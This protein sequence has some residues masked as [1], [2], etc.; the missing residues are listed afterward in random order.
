METEKEFNDM[1]QGVLFLAYSE[2][3]T[4]ELLKRT[5]QKKGISSREWH[6]IDITIPCRNTKEYNN[7]INFLK[8]F[9]NPIAKRVMEAIPD[10]FMTNQIL[11]KIEKATDYKLIRE[12]QT[13]ETD[14]I[15]PLLLTCM[16]PIAVEY[17]KRY[18]DRLKDEEAKKNYDRLLKFESDNYK[19]KIL[20]Y[21]SDGKMTKD[22]TISFED[23]SNDIKNNY[24]ENKEENRL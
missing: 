23:L 14:N 20:R 19:P 13:W 5:L 16:T 3:E 12:M 18:K 8:S 22:S 21:D 1:E 2:P 11:K 9:S 4:W 10:N 6:L 7:T 15:N 24:N 17:K